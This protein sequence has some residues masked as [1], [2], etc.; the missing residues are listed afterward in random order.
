MP[1]GLR[2]IDPTSLPEIDLQAEIPWHGQSGGDDLLAL[3]MGR[4]LGGGSEDGMKAAGPSTAMMAV[5]V[6]ANAIS[7]PPARTLVG[8]RFLDMIDIGHRALGVWHEKKGV[9]TAVGALAINAAVFLAT[10]PAVCGPETF[11]SVTALAVGLCSG[12]D[13][14]TVLGRGLRALSTLG[15]MAVRAE[16]R[17]DGELAALLFEPGSGV[18]DAIDWGAMDTDPVVR[19]TALALHAYRGGAD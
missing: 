9:R 2:V 15:L 12:E 11:A 17:G 1:A 13:D 4:V 3:V 14:P 10:E 18:V 7:L 19:Q 6:L 8:H 16:A 5:R